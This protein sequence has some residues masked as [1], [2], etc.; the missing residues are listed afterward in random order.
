MHFG[1]VH[2]S[3]EAQQHLVDGAPDK[4]NGGNE[5][6]KRRH[7]QTLLNFNRDQML[8]VLH[9]HE[10]PA[11]CLDSAKND[12]WNWIKLIAAKIKQNIETRGDWY[13]ARVRNCRSS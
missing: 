13:N 9:C 11:S 7:V 3:Y 10:G 2:S 5:S 1:I 4:I 12:R 8:G 6:Y